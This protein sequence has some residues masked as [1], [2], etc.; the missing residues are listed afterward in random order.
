MCWIESEE[1][2]AAAV[3]GDYK[4]TT[5]KAK[6]KLLLHTCCLVD[7]P[8]NGSEMHGN[9]AVQTHS[10]D[11]THLLSSELHEGWTG[12]LRGG[13]ISRCEGRGGSMSRC[14]GRGGS[15]SSSLL[16]A[17]GSRTVSSTVRTG[18]RGTGGRGAR[19]LDDR[20]NL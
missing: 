13:S 20:L 14:E 3:V 19:R 4:R 10:H 2:E 18:T 12:P 8:V 16:P 6:N 1:E 5:S 17:P 9:A 11:V 7:Q 15:M